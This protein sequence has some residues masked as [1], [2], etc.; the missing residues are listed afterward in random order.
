MPAQ[1][2]GFLIALAFLTL[3]SGCGT[4]HP[5]SDRLPAEAIV[6]TD[7]LGRTVILP[8]RP[9]RIISL[10][11]ANT[12]IL[13]AVGAGEQI[14][15]VTQYANYPDVAAEIAQVGGFSANSISLETVVGLQPDVVFAEGDLH[16]TLIH[17]F[18]QLRIP[19]IAFDPA[20]LEDV[21]ENIRIAGRVTENQDRADQVVRNMQAAVAAVQA[22]RL[23]ATPKVF[24]L[25][26]DTPLMTAGRSS[27]ISQLIVLAGGVNAF[28]DVEE[29]FPQVSEEAILQRNPD[30]IIAPQRDGDDN[31][32]ERIT[33]RANWRNLSAVQNGRIHFID[34]DWISRP[35][36]RLVSGL[37]AVADAIRNAAPAT[38][39]VAKPVVPAAADRGESE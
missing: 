2:L 24:Y 22:A 14:V 30:V 1:I 32:L 25:A 35:G 4:T 7:S 3:V 12:E 39:S 26:W 31:E 18:E 23:E 20:T 10:A 13:F 33:A 15:G 21:Y 34:E 9:E 36:P 11:P 16:R 38:P 6:L 19:V 17:R 37:H 27:F 29:A 5:E 8:H 28:G